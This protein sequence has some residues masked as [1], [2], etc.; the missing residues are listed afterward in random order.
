MGK[1][2]IAFSLWGNIPLYNKGAISNVHEAKEIYPDWIC[3]F[4]VHEHSPVINDLRNLACEVI[5]M[6]IER[7]FIPA[8]WRF[9]AASDPDV[10]I[11]LM[12]DCDSRVNPREAAAVRDWLLTDKNVHIM[13]DWP[14]PHATETILAGMWGIRGGVIP[15]MKE[16]VV[17][18]VSKD[19]VSNKYTDQDFLRFKIFPMIKHSIF[20]HGVN[21]PAGEAI[22]FP[23]HAPMKYGEYVGQAIEVE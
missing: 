17:E 4:Y 8:F 13:K 11:T 22:P 3:R 14:A 19:N 20:N 23:S 15:N 9:Y 10:D 2:I 16:L 5:P 12:R 1:K 6:P 21:S 7:H 18:W